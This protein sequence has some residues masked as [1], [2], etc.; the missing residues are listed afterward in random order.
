MQSFFVQFIKT[1]MERTYVIRCNISN[2]RKG[3]SSN[4][5]TPRK[6]VEKRTHRRVCVFSVTSRC[7]VEIGRKTLSIVFF[8]IVVIQLRLLSRILQRRPLFQGAL[9]RRFWCILVTTAQIFDKEHV[10][11]NWPFFFKLQSTSIQ[12]IRSQT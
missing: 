6:G 12:A 11:K 8:I 2:T 4:F 1:V 5:Q 9:P 3:V 7:L 10:L